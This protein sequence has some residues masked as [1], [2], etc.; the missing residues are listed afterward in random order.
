[1]NSLID[2]F[3][4]LGVGTETNCRREIFEIQS[5]A[6]PRVSSSPLHFR[7]RN[8]LSEG[9]ESESFKLGYRQS[10]AEETE[11]VRKHRMA[12]PGAK[13]DNGV[14]GNTNTSGI[15]ARIDSE[16]KFHGFHDGGDF[17]KEN[18]QMHFAEL[19]ETALK[20]QSTMKTMQ[21]NFGEGAQRPAPNFAY[22]YGD[23]VH[24]DEV[25]GSSSTTVLQI[26]KNGTHS[27][28]GMGVTQLKHKR[29]QDEAFSP[30]GKQD[31]VTEIVAPGMNKINGHESDSVLSP[32]QDPE[33]FLGEKI[34][35]EA[36][37]KPKENLEIRK[38]LSSLYSD[39]LVVDSVPAAKKVVQK[40]TTSYK[41]LVHACDTEV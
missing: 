14:G 11:L 35:S 1:M 37:V 12:S 24:H 22:Q 10:W 6:N 25:N 30:N 17:N 31:L 8:P 3:S 7:K 4:V 28:L 39:V 23:E 19:K 32:T 34:S 2:K 38:Q 15:S 33:E 9:Y 40:L 29:R 5:S 26:P 20:T 13:C 27:N 16:Q 41:H 18:V 36:V 21:P